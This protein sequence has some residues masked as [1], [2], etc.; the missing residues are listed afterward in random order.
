VGEGA[1]THVVVDTDKESVFQS[2]KTGT[3]D[4]IALENNCRF[5]VAGNSTGLHNLIGK[6][7]G[8]VDTRDAVVE[9]DVCLLAHFA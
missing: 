7:E 4:A 2:L 6:R 1:P 3:V 9:N 5:I 8:L